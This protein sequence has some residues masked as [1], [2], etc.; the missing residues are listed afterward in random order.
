ME[1]HIVDCLCHWGP[2]ITLGS[3]VSTRTILGQMKEAGVERA[4]VMPFPSTAAT[5]GEINVRLLNEARRVEEFIPYFHIRE[6]LLPM[7]GKYYGCSWRR[8]RGDRDAG[9]NY[10]IFEDPRLSN[11]IDD[12]TMTGKPILFEEDL[13]FTKR[14]AEMADRLSLIVP[15][16]GMTGG[17]P[18]DFLETFK[19]KPNVCFSTALAGKE[20]I[21]RFIEA[22]G[23]ERVL[24]GSNLPFGSMASE[25]SKIL[26]LPVSDSDKESILGR[27]I[28]RLSG[29]PLSYTR[30]ATT[31]KALS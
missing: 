11:L 4:V 13:L 21:V 31:S 25:V 15:H 1:F 3:N 19:N 6:D 8:M 22:I 17:D 26:S 24:F 18:V 12:L 28:V 16:L 7:P 30:P 29:L 9:S 23:P 20:M 2:S 5:S 10:A 27:N 14:F